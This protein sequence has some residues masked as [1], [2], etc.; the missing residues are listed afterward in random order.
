MGKIVVTGDVLRVG[1]AGRPDQWVNIGWLKRLLAP[2]LEIATG[3]GE[4]EKVTWIAHASNFDGSM[5]YAAH[6]LE[7]SAGNWAALYHQE[8]SSLALAYLAEFFQG[9]TVIG[10]E[11]SPYLRRALNQL[12]ATYLDLSVHP[13]RFMEDLAL[14]ISSNNQ[15]ISDL[16]EMFAL[17][18]AD[19]R[20]RSTFLSG[21]WRQQGYVQPRYHRAAMI[22]LQTKFDRVLIDRGKFVS[23]EQY[24]PQLKEIRREFDRV[25]VKPHPHGSSESGVGFIIDQLDDVE[26]VHKNFYEMIARHDIDDVYSISSGTSTEARFLGLQGHH[27]FRDYYTAEENR[28]GGGV[29]HA[30]MDDVLWPDFWR[31]ILSPIMPVT[32]LGGYRKYTGRDTLRKALGQSWDFSKWS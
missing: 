1:P 10:F 2:A 28:A 19:L 12:N 4:I 25:Y 31:Q 5:V 23:I 16:V 9:A 30:V 3:A 17:S 20:L 24:L 11:L 27:L 29:Y 13:V 32:G 8:P 14:Y 26:I 15:A 6:D 22:C 18:D 21:A 7:P